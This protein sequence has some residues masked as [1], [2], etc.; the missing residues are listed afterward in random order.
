MVALS[1]QTDNLFFK[2]NKDD[3]NEKKKR[4]RKRIAAYIIYEQS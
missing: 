2:V 4:Q 3:D 1:S